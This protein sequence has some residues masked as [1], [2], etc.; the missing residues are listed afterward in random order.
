[1]SRPT[2]RLSA[3]LT[4]SDTAVAPHRWQVFNLPEPEP[5]EVAEHQAY[6]CRCRAC[7]YVTR[8][9][10]PEGV[11]APVHYGLR[12]RAMAVYLQPGHF[13]PEAR[14][15]ELIRGPVPGAGQRRHAGGD[16]ATDGVALAGR[17]RAGARLAGV[18]RPK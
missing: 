6:A 8:A 1:M 18:G 17:C 5:L 14:L 16:G 13:L 4:E 12:L 3:P 15:A 7:G 2:C 9:A 10:F 11:K